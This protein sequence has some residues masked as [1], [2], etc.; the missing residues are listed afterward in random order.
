MSYG[1]R[2]KDGSGRITL[3]TS[4]RMGRFLGYLRVTGAGSLNV[5]D[6]AQGTPFAFPIVEATLGGLMSNWDVR[7]IGTVVS[8]APTG[9][10]AIPAFIYYGVY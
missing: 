3:D 1:I 8:W 10:G 9:Q 2:I 6:L 7:A 4:W 5:P